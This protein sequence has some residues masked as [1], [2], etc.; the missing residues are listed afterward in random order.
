MLSELL[1]TYPDNAKANE[2]SA[3]IAGMRGNEDLAFTLL[4]KAT[5][6]AEASQEAFYYLG[7]AYLKRQLYSEA[8]TAFGKALKMGGEFFEGLHD[9]GVSLAAMGRY[10]KALEVFKKALKLNQNSHEMYYNIGRTYEALSQYEQALATY[11][12]S[13]Q[14]DPRFPNA[15]YNRGVA[16]N[17]LNRPDEALEAYAKAVSLNPGY[18]KAWSNLAITLIELRAYAKSIEAY[19]KL[20]QLQ[21]DTDYAYGNWVHAKMMLCRWDSFENDIATLIEQV[22]AGE[23]ASLPFNFLATPAPLPVLK[24]CSETHAADRFKAKRNRDFTK[25]S[26]SHECIKIGYFSADFYNHATTYLMAELFELH[27]RSKFEIIGIS[28]GPNKADEMQQRVEAAFDKFLDARNLTDEQIADWV[29]KEKINIAVDLKGFTLN[30]RPGIFAWQ[31]APIQVNYIGYPG[32]MGADYFDYLI[33]DKTV[34][35]EDHLTHYSEKVVFLPHSYQVNDRKRQISDKKFTRKDV[36]LPEEGFVFACFNN[37]FKIT[38]DVFDIWMNLLSKVPNSIFWFFEGAADV[39]ANLRLEAKKRGI[40]PERLIFAPHMPLT[41]HLARIQHADLF[42]DTFYYGAHTTASDALWVGLP[43]LTYLGESFSARVAASL[44][45]AVG[46]PELITHTREEYAER[47]YELSTYPGK[48]AAIRSKLASLRA[49]A[50]LFNTPQ[51]A[52]DIETAYSIMWD[53]YRSGQV[54]DHIYVS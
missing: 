42:L 35:A 14:L 34:I 37:N 28:F 50:P 21:S 24:Q 26:F 54:P 16:L 45:N 1:R 5:R 23:K 30:S 32:T 51:F 8:A 49:E 47:A 33:G 3:Y 25:N 41:D 17:R 7:T 10:E 29:R 38:P 53:R 18:A 12:M 52:K 6:K 22:K 19:E 9:L 44:L 46:M 43:I 36:G 13:V 4:K 11:D 27:D 39:L 15:W 2:L 48:L 40:A 31:P 20:F